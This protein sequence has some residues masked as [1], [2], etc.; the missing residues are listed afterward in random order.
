[1]NQRQRK[2]L[3]T[4]ALAGI[5]AGVTGCG[6]APPPEAASPAAEPQGEKSGCKAEMGE[7]HSCGGEMKNHDMKDG[8]DTSAAPP[9][10]P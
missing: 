10:N 4:L 7:K 1:M 6:G 3:I 9:A 2:T 8:D 5:T